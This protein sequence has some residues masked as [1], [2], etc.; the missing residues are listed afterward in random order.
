M[1]K[2]TDSDIM[3][4]AEVAE[5]FGLSSSKIYQCA[6]AGTIPAFKVAGSWRFSKTHIQIWVK[7]QITENVNSGQ[8]SPLR[9]K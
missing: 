5:Y 8:S 1:V 3:T 4:I 6:R 9:C 7:E 2:L